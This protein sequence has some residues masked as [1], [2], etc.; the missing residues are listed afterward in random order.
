ML[1]FFSVPCQPLLC[2]YFLLCSLL[3]PVVLVF[4]SVPCQHSFLFPVSPCFA[5]MF[6]SSLCQPMLCLHLLFPVSLCC[7]C[8]ALLLI[9]EAEAPRLNSASGFFFSSIGSGVWPLL[10]CT[11]LGPHNEQHISMPH[12]PLTIRIVRTQTHSGGDSV[13]LGVGFS[14][15]RPPAPPPLP[16]TLPSPPAPE[17]SVLVLTTKCGGGSSTDLTN[18]PFYSLGV[19]PLVGWG[20]EGWRGSFCRVAAEQRPFL[21]RRCGVSGSDHHLL[22][23]GCCC[24]P[25]PEQ[26]A[27]G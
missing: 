10:V 26:T 5:C 1:I 16:P 12:T 19:R 4:C 13:A 20:G 7:A 18:Q 3:T 6:C 27:N 24:V 2:L 22:P 9:C 8:I 11:W 23:L 15:R 17:I 25:S 14:R 21:V